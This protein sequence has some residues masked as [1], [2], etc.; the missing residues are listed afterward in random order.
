MSPRQRRRCRPENDEAPRRRHRL[1]LLP[2]RFRT[3]IPAASAPKWGARDAWR[4]IK[5]PRPA[6]LPASA[7]FRCATPRHAAHLDIAAAVRH[8]ASAG[9]AVAIK[10]PGERAAPWP[11]RAN[12]RTAP[13]TAGAAARAGVEGEKGEQQGRKSE[14][15][16]N[17]PCE[18]SLT[19]SDCTCAVKDASDTG[20][21]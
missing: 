6:P 4:Q 11:R 18:L 15:K 3:I 10:L 1:H 13:R 7:S 2:A 14:R 21:T 19:I 20:E 8:G 17:P 9:G 12:S 16:T 5:P